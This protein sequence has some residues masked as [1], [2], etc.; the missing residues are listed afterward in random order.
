MASGVHSAIPDDGSFVHLGVLHRS[1]PLLTPAEYQL[2]NQIA[3]GAQRYARRAGA[4][5]ALHKGATQ[6]EAGERAGLTDR[7]VRFWLAEFREKRL[8]I[9]PEAIRAAAVEVLD[10]ASDIQEAADGGADMALVAG[11]PVAAKPEPVASVQRVPDPRTS[12]TAPVLCPEVVTGIGPDDT[13]TE[14]ARKKLHDYFCA[15]LAHEPGARLGENPEEL[16]KMRVATRRMRAAVQVFDRYVDRQVM[17]SHLR[18]MRRTA[19]VLGRVRDLDVG[20]EKAID[21][22]R[23]KA[24]SGVDLG[25]LLSAWRDAHRMARVDLLAYLDSSAYLRFKEDFAVLLETPLPAPDRLSDLDIVPTRLRHVVPIE[26]Y[27]RLAEV[28]AFEEVIGGEK[29]DL[30]HYHNLRIACKRL[31]YT[32]EFFEH[33]LGPE[34]KQAIGELKEMQDYLGDF[35][36]AVVASDRLRNFWLWGTWD[37]PAKAQ[38]GKR[39]VRS[40]LAPGVARYHTEKQLEIEA[41]LEGFA[42][43]WAQ[44]QEPDFCRLIARAISIL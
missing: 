2:L 33:I 40:I 19:K 44:Y 3:C 43:V 4:L 8:D 7:R 37:A 15:M 27:A 34:V 6:V 12:D 24:G 16:H 42:E 25:P 36:D 14:A 23:S 9:F 28:R 1:V 21:F 20:I 11:D 39:R 22:T 17:A 29:V 32:L 38:M 5:V 31:R 18:S 41:A 10:A 26:I 35:Q 30:E 13:M